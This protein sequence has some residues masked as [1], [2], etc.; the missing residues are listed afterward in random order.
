[1]TATR[2]L[3]VVVVSL[4]ALAIACSPPTATTRPAGSAAATADPNAAARTPGPPLPAGPVTY[5]PE[6]FRADLDRL[7]DAKRYADAVN[8]VRAAD[9]R[10]QV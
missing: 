5:A 4:A 2:P 3:V 9:V 6:T 7:I 1:M 10:R 8:L